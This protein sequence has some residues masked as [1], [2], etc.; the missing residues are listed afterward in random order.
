M[1]YFSDKA[2]GV[3]LGFTVALSQFC[4]S[5]GWGK[6]SKTLHGACWRY[7]ALG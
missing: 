6:V 1:A 5:T 7:T 3:L 2:G 4:E